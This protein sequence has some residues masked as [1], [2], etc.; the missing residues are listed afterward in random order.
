VRSDAEVW[1][2]VNSLPEAQAFREKFPNAEGK[3]WRDSPYYHKPYEFQV[4][5]AAS[6][7]IQR[8]AD[9]LYSRTLALTFT[10]GY[11]GLDWTFMGCGLMPTY[12]SHVTVEDIRTNECL[13]P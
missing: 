4:S 9:S 3:I 8:G 5:L 13:D 7:Q 12:L 11:S 10:M 1:E 6:K 2:Y